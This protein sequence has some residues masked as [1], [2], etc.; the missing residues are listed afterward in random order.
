MYWPLPNNWLACQIYRFSPPQQNHLKFTL[1]FSRL[2]SHVWEYS[3]AVFFPACYYIK[4][5]Q[6]LLL[7]AHF[8]QHDFRYC[9]RMYG[10]GGTFSQWVYGWKFIF[11]VWISENV[12]VTFLLSDNWN[13]GRCLDGQVC[14]LNPL[15]IL[16]H[17]LWAR[18]GIFIITIIIFWLRIQCAFIIW[19]LT[20]F[21]NFEKFLLFLLLFRSSAVYVDDLELWFFMGDF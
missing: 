4:K 14:F 18:W 13:E 10:L 6:L 17:C 15:R 8:Y 11:S 19:E 12:Y 1:L 16:F 20:F 9:W 5:V 2:K 21:F 3:S 7:A